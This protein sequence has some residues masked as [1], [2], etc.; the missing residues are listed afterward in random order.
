MA[1]QRPTASGEPQNNLPPADARPPGY[2][3][4]RAEARALSRS[5]PLTPSE[6]KARRRVAEQRVDPL[7]VL[8]AVDP[9]ANRPGEQG[10]APS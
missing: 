7:P 5:A 3:M 2:T 1:R 4:T 6:F 10:S 8:L 9:S